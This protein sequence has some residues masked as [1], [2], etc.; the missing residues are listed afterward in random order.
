[1]LRC[2]TRG[3]ES[4]VLLLGCVP[5]LHAQA[6]LATRLVLHPPTV[7]LNG[8]Q[9]RHR[10]L[11]TAVAPD[12]SLRDVTSAVK[13]TCQDG[14]VVA[15]AA[16]GE[17]VA[18]KDGQTLVNVNYGGQSVPLRVVVRDTQQVRAASFVNDVIPILTRLGCNQGVL[19]RQRGGAKWLP[20]IVARLRSRDGSRLDHPRICRPANRSGCPRK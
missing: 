2:V 14:G 10:I 8:P 5:F 7:E 13:Y 1:M 3:I 20:P 12:G 4:L 17:C 15:V 11:V 19:P 6:P 18:R 16:V 9:A